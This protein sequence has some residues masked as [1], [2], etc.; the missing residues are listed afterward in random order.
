MEF[1][2]KRFRSPA[3]SQKISQ[4]HGQVIRVQT[5]YG[6]TA[7]LPL[8]H[9]AAA[10]YNPNQRTTLEDDFQALRQFITPK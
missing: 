8:F 9:P 5:A 2:L 6:Q 3:A 7:V 4:L 1:I 10:L